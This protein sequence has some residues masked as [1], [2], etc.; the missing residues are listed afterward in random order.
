LLLATAGTGALAALAARPRRAALPLVQRTARALGMEVSIQVR[1][2]ST[3]EAESA[4]DA[5]L[6]ELRLIERL[7]SVYD[8]ESQLSRLNRTGCLR[9]P[10]PYLV[11]VL[12]QAQEV[13]RQTGGAFDATVQ[14]LWEL[15]AAAAKSGRL[16]MADE[17]TAARRLVD[18]RQVQVEGE[19][20]RLLRPGMKLTLNGIAQ[21]FATDCVQRVLEEHGI[22][23]ALFSIGEL[24]ALGRSPRGDA[25]C[26]GIQ[27]P[28]RPEA[29]LELA[30]LDGRALATSGDYA[31][32]FT[33]DRRHHHIFDPRTGYSP[34]ELA[35]VSIAAPTAIEA[36]ALSTACFVLGPEGS[37][38]LLRGLRGID[39]LLVLKDGET[40]TTPGFPRCEGRAV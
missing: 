34:G 31:T 17:V 23:H 20:I 8:P 7:M 33:T 37:L 24:G 9:Q 14:P 22:E 1:H 38:T 26:V 12:R 19:E 18:W 27:D 6:A 16:P 15:F 2:G 36:D 28:R 29:Y 40:I 4:I 5:A 32:T 30:E 11:A 3:L 13:A 25:W 21:G 35:S 39:G 10:H